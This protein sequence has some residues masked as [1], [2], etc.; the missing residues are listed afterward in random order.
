MDRGM[1][2]QYQYRAYSMLTREK[3]IQNAERYSVIYG[4]QSKNN[5]D[6]D[7]YCMVDLRAT[8]ST[9]MQ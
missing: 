6:T 4:N 1:E 2:V 5:S 8:L 9:A 7:G 3:K